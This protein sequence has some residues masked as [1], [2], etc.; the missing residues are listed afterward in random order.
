MRSLF[1]FLALFAALLLPSSSA[2]ADPDWT[3]PVRGPVLTKFL[4]GDDPYAA[5]QHRGIDIGAAVGTPVVAAT[6]GTVVYAGVVGSSGL[7][8]AERAGDYELSYLHLSSA[9]VRSGDHVEAG[10][11][12]GA[13]GV[14]GT[15]S[16][17]EAHL[18]FGVRSAADRHAYLDPLRFLP[19]PSGPDPKPQAAPVPVQEPVAAPAPVAAAPA[20]VGAPLVAPAP[21]PIHALAPDRHFARAP[22]GVVAPRHLGVFAPRVEAAAPVAPEP[23]AHRAAPARPDGAATPGHGPAAQLAAGH[24]ASATATPEG[25]AT[26]RGRGIDLGWLAACS[27][28]VLAAA[29][30]ARPRAGGPRRPPLR[31]ALAMLLRAAA[32]PARARA[33]Q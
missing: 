3:W 10:E 24:S 5:G 30:L 6:A 7:T 20:P 25:E 14:S 28:L 33:R 9:S 16:V 23:A 19:P 1:F 26:R 11:R 31:A 29:L 21:A 12:L 8:V 2:L 15:R 17:E 22:S 13:V 32:T 4:N 18:H 27:G